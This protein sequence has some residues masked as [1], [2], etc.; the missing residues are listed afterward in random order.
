MIAYFK[1][2]NE[3]FKLFGIWQ[4]QIN[5]PTFCSRT[6]TALGHNPNEVKILHYGYIL[7]NDTSYTF[8][9]GHNLNLI[10]IDETDV[11]IEGKPKKIKKAYV[12][13]SIPGSILHKP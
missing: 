12:S 3:E 4:D 7:R 6:I 5:D 9:E 2:E 1:K 8:D 10:N 13:Q 11:E